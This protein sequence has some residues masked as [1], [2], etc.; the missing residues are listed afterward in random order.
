MDRRALLAAGLAALA[1]CLPLRGEPA[2]PGRNVNHPQMLADVAWLPDESAYRVRMLAGNRFTPENTRSV[3]VV[4]E[5]DRYRELSW[6]GGASPAQSFPLDV[7]DE[8][9]VPVGSRGDVR[10]V[11]TG[12]DGDRSV[13]LEHHEDG[14][15]PSMPGDDRT[16]TS[17]PTASG[18]TT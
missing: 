14:A 3:R 4:V 8:L 13:S 11:W 2:T 12:P 9:L 6:V 10:V 18:G 15:R 16:P 5:T 1:G 7:G 17:V